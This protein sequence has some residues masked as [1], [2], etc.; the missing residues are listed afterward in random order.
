MSNDNVGYDSG[1]DMEEDTESSEDYIDD[2]D[3]DQD[4]ESSS[5]EDDNDADDEREKQL[6][7]AYQAI[8]Y[9][10]AD[11]P[12]DY[13]SYVQLIETASALGDLSKLRQAREDMSSKFPLTPILWLQWIQNEEKIC[14]SEED[15]QEIVNLF[16]RAIQ[17]YTSVDIWLEYV[18]FIIGFI[19]KEN[20]LN[21]IRETFERAVHNVGLHVTKGV[22]IWE[23]YREFEMALISMMQAEEKVVQYKR[24]FDIFKRQLS[25]PLFEMEKAYQEFEEWCSTALQ[26]CP[27][28][29]VDA[30]DVK[31]IYDR[32]YAQLQKLKPFEDELISSQYPHLEQY[33]KYIEF[34]KVNGNPPRVQC[35]YE[36]AFLDN[37]LV[38]DL[39]LSYAQYLD[40]KVN[41]PDL[42]YSVYERS[43]RNCPW[44]VSLWA[45]YIHT[46]ERNKCDSGKIIEVFERSLSTGFQ[47]SEEYREIWSVYLSYLRRHTKWDDEKEIDN[48]RKNFQ[49]CI[50]HLSNWEDG[51]PTCS[52]HFYLAKIEAKYCNNLNEARNYLNNLFRERKDI[53]ARAEMW[54][55]FANFERTFGDEKHYKKVLLRSLQSVQDW[56]E[57][58]GLVLLKY[59]QEEGSS[60]Q[61]YDEVMEKYLNA[62]KKATERREREAKQK[63]KKQEVMQSKRGAKKSNQSNLKRKEPFE[64]TTSELSS[65]KVSF[66]S[67]SSSFSLASALSKEEAATESK[68]VKLSSTATH[69]QSILAEMKRQ[70]ELKDSHD[71]TKNL[72]TVFVSNLDFKLD[73]EYLRNIFSK[74]GQIVDIRLVRNYKGLSKG[75]CYIEYASIEGA[76]EALK[77][78]RM[79]LESRPAFVSE[80]GRRSGL[81]FKTGLEKNKLYVNNLSP[82]VDS[83]MLTQ[84]FEKYGKL[85]DVRLVTF[86]NGHSKGCA[87]VEFDKESTASAALEADG[88]LLLDKHIR[89]MISDPSSKLKNQDNRSQQTKILGAGFIQPSTSR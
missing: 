48:L 4:E 80:M 37:C 64:S 87:Y 27:A 56:P 16:E 21:K 12:Y 84:L 22:S 36:R 32:A 8:R 44:N 58:I 10:L 20:G 57:T 2:P 45:S 13:D 24:V 43:L 38:A 79:M 89:V 50:Q 67:S 40:K 74:F 6:E 28:C 68:K 66:T 86:R 88:T 73:E 78:D 76:K 3:D 5:Q 29:E 47:K 11:N 35:I 59:E 39:W 14:T 30:K 18:Q 1:E 15:K 61:D 71:E 85:K 70:S 81:K 82:N 63:A 72:H 54:I 62:I 42:V 51:D 65:S 49:T 23:G 7:E 46:L 75:Y 19:E 53:A 9:K 26:E 41:I 69:D 77:H 17:D 83:K 52:F 31:F 34:E 60:I 33:L 25:V 55:E